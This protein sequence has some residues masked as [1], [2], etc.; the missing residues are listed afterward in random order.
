MADNA[1]TD[2]QLSHHQSLVTDGS[3]LSVKDRSQSGTDRSFGVL[4]VGALL[5]VIIMAVLGEIVALIIAA[6]GLLP[7]SGLALLITITTS[8]V[9]HASG[10][11]SW[12]VSLGTCSYVVH[13]SHI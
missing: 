2:H 12:R 13:A 9:R 4:R 1:V 5:F 6:R 10:W 3:W 8:S 11:S 7:R